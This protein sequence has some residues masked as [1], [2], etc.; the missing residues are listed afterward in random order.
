MNTKTII[1]IVAVGGVVALGAVWSMAGNDGEIVTDNETNTEVTTTANTK[2][3][4]VT[5]PSDMPANTPIYPES[6][7][8]SVQ[9]SEANA[10][11]NIILTLTTPDSVS[12]VNTWYRGAL[13]TGG[14]AVTSDK[15]VGGYVLLKGENG[16][17]AVFTQAAPEGD[18]GLTVITHRVQIK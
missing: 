9:R 17:L 13:K 16:N 4:A 7:V 5:V 14:W 11:K 3:V 8:R 10:V 1:G 2:T 18:S 6:I 15:T 12:D